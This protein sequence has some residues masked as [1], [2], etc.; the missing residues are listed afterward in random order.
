LTREGQVAYVSKQDAEEFFLRSP[1]L[2]P[3][4]VYIC[5]NGTQQA[6]GANVSP[7]VWLRQPWSTIIASNSRSISLAA[8]LNQWM[9]GT[10]GWEVL[11]VSST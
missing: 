2:H 11:L 1:E 5:P 3:D 9:Q 6:V 4:Y 10:S 8:S 7:C